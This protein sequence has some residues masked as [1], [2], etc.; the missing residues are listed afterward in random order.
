MRPTDLDLLITLAEA[1]I[2]ALF[3]VLAVWTGVWGIRERRTARQFE[4]G[5]RRKPERKAL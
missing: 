4:V 2:G 1:T 3:L 5:R